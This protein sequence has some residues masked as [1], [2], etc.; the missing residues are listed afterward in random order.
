M[1]TQLNGGLCTHVLTL[2]LYPWFTKN[3]CRFVEKCISSVSY[4]ENQVPYTN[5]TTSTFTL[6]QFYRTAEDPYT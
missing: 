3:L 6:S 1:K 2:K 4:E 5:A